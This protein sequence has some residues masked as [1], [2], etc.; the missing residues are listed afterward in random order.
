MGFALEAFKG[1]L[2]PSRP[3]GCLQVLVGGKSVRQPT[4]TGYLDQSYC[5]CPL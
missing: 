4:S 1:A 2:A 3:D 5:S